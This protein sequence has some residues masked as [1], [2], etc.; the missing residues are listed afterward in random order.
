MSGLMFIFPVFT[1]LALTFITGA[2]T[3]AAEQPAVQK[4]APA[5]E[6]TITIIPY[7]SPEKLWAKFSPLIDYLKEATGKP[8]TLKLYPN[9]DQTIEAICKGEVSFALLGPVPLARSIERCGTDIV[10]VAVGSDGTLFYHSL[11]VTTDPTVTSLSQLKGR[12]IGLFRGSTAAHIVPMKMLID[13]GIGKDR[14]KPLFFE[15]Q[16]RIMNALLNGEVT[17]AGIKDVL[18]K[19]FKDSR[20]RVL[21]ASKPLPNFAFAAAPNLNSRTKA[22]FAGALLKLKPHKNESDRRLV[23]DWDDEIKNGFVA[24]SASYGPSVMDLLSVYR[25][26]MSA[27]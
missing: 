26:V 6:Y 16:D 1:F 5:S 19:R 20:L 25:E 23:K 17:A 11:I 8:W 3:T 13:A 24:P 4:T 22:L 14:I 21:Q 12:Q 7:Y 18:Y 10:T 15:G 9:H 27:D 2:S